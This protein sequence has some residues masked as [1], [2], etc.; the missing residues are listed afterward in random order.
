MDTQK[1]LQADVLDII[2]DNRNKSYGA[3]ELRKNYAKRLRNGFA[4]LAAITLFGFAVALFAVLSEDPVSAST[5]HGQVELTNYVDLPKPPDPEVKTPEHP[6]V[7]DPQVD[8]IPTEIV[9]ADEVKDPEIKDPEITQPDLG[10]GDENSTTKPGGEPSGPGGGDGDIGGTKP[11]GP[12]TID[13]PIEETDN[14]FEME[15]LEALPEY[16]GGEEAMMKYLLSQIKYPTQ[17]IENN[18]SGRVTLGFI[19]DK[20]GN[21]DEIKILKSVGYGCDEEAVRVV[22]NMPNWKPG[23]NNGKP[24]KVYFNLPI[25]FQVQ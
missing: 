9:V 18:V 10:Q 16:P 17:A 8:P 25:T 12:T 22:K 7:K 19:V 1:I 20:N 4:S 14:T 6:E 21:I 5:R 11:E 15:T 2:F 24:V 23:K 3:Y 13:P